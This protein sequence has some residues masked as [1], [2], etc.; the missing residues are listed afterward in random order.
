MIV[1]VRGESLS[2]ATRLHFLF[3]AS[4]TSAGQ[5]LNATGRNAKQTHHS[6]GKPSKTCFLQ[7]NS[8][9][10][11][12]ETPLNLIGV[13]CT[14]TYRFESKHMLAQLYSRFFEVQNARKSKCKKDVL[15]TH[16]LNTA[17]D[18]SSDICHNNFSIPSRW[19]SHT[20]KTS[21]NCMMF[22]EQKDNY[23]CCYKPYQ[24]DP[25]FV[26]VLFLFIAWKCK[27]LA[28]VAF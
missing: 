5:M 28:S 4:T 27:E 24:T 18:C 1:S 19:K 13:P 7:E 17:C 25:S 12:Q 11:C 21:P 6:L 3:M 23:K 16:K 2:A 8:V 22:F 20:H 15:S 10:V 9:P 14:G 26:L